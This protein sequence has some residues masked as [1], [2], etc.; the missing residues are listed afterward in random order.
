MGGTWAA[1]C[2]QNIV[3]LASDQIH[4]S[5]GCWIWGLRRSL[6][7]QKA[8]SVV[9][10]PVSTPIKLIYTAPLMCTDLE[11]CQLIENMWG[12]FRWASY[13]YTGQWAQILENMTHIQQSFYIQYKSQYSTGMMMHNCDSRWVHKLRKTLRL[14]LCPPPVW[15]RKKK[16]PLAQCQGR[17]LA[18]YQWDHS[19]FRPLCLSSETLHGSFLF[20]TADEDCQDK[21]WSL[22][23]S[24]YRGRQQ[25]CTK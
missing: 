17:P 3:L 13:F 4:W 18:S 14:C 20:L 11:W 5:S 8:T 21:L 24:R 19:F 2:K 9:K 1:Q 23:G 12:V 7:Q 16:E 10:W 15:L 6:I 25:R 22:G